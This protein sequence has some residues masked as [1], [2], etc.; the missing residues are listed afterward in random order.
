MKIVQVKDVQSK[1]N[2]A[3]SGCQSISDTESAQVA[4]HITCSRER[5]CG[6]NIS[7]P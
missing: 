5:D 2:P 3:W 7:H 1:P 6:K 4:A